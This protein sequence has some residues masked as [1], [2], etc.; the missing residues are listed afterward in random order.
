MNRNEPKQDGWSNLECLQHAFDDKKSS[1]K[2]WWF[3]SILQESDNMEKVDIS[4][5]DLIIRVLKIAFPF[6]N[7]KIKFCKPSIRK[8]KTSKNKKKHKY[9]SDFIWNAFIENKINEIEDITK[10]QE[11]KFEKIS[12]N[13]SKHVKFHFL[14][15]FYHAFNKKIDKTRGEWQKE[16][17]KLSKKENKF[18]SISDKGIS[19]NSEMKFFLKNNN[20]FLKGWCLFHL[21]RYLQKFNSKKIINFLSVDQIFC[22]T[23]YRSLSSISNFF[24]SNAQLC[25]DPYNN[26]TRIAHEKISLDHI[27]PFSCIGEDSMWNIIPC[28]KDINS[29]KNDRIPDEKYI[30]FIVRLQYDI[31]HKLLKEENP[32]KDDYS[33]LPDFLPDGE[34]GF[35]I[36]KQR[37]LEQYYKTY[38]NLPIKPQI[39]TR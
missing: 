13:L 21:C 8:G 14:S 26:N 6:Y 9:N 23:K 3:L 30:D 19:L 5:K 28:S 15:P 4:F 12:N 25:I 10:I 31:Y 20:V 27:I 7:E 24:K 2:F 17:T 38:N 37:W 11:K 35:N 1:Y 33:F 32:L 16:I 18:Y 39:W 22:Y 29:S 36:F 34:K